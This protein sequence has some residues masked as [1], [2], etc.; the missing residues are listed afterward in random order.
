M[1]SISD[2]ADIESATQLRSVSAQRPSN[3]GLIGLLYISSLTY[4]F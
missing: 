1:T 3:I 4:T 2:I